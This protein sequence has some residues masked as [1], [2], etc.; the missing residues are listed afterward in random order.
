MGVWFS[1]KTFCKR[2]AIMYD[3]DRQ[4]GKHA[5]EIGLEWLTKHRLP[6]AIYVAWLKRVLARYCLESESDLRSALI[7]EH[8]LEKL[9][10]Q[11]RLWS[12]SFFVY[13]TDAGI[14]RAYNE[15][16]PQSRDVVIEA[17]ERICRHEFELLGADATT[18]GSPLNWHRDPKSGYCWPRL[19]FAELR[20]V[21]SVDNDADVKLPYEFSR[22]Q[23]LPTLGIAY[24]LTRDE[25][26]AE[27]LVAQVSHWLDENPCLMGVNWTCGMD[28]AMRIVNILWGMAFI[29]PQSSV[30]TLAFKQRLLASIWEHGQYLVRHLELS[31][32]EDGTLGNH[33]HYLSNITGLVYLG[34]L[35]PEFKAAERWRQLG[36][37]GLIEEM[38]RQVLNDGADYESSLSYHRLVVELFT[39]SAVLCRLND[40]DLPDTFWDKLEK[41]YTLTLYATR[42]DGRMPQVGD[43]DDGRLHI[44]SGYGQWD[45]MD[46][47][48]LLAIGAVLFERADMK[49]AADGK[50]EEAFWL[51]GQQGVL[52]FDMLA[53]QL[54]LL[55]SRAFPDAGLYVMRS[56]STYLLV[57]CGAVNS[58]VSGNHKHNDLLSFELCVGDVPFIIDPG[59]Y[60]Y[61][62][63][64]EWRNRFRSTAYHNTVVI[65][66]VEQNRFCE[67]Q[68]FR[69][70]PD[71]EVVVHECLLTDEYDRLEV[72]HAG[73]QRLSSPVSHRRAFWFDKRSPAL[74][75]TDVL[76]GD[77]EHQAEWYYH[78]DYG[79]EVSRTDE[80]RFI[81]R[82]GEV[83]LMIQIGA[84]TA[85]AAELLDGWVSRRYGVKLP[86]RILKLCS[87]FSGELRVTFEATGV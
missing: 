82:A 44:L 38:D 1:F 14:W 31:V 57:S 80:A 79:V 50:V 62:G 9:V 68:L 24:G 86:S 47:R 60:I 12:Q 49:A 75:I 11:P 77:G 46:H 51:L 7:Y 35:F 66:A 13:P 16:L 5:I 3:C 26:Y 71:A 54:P 87:T 36:I 41:M 28:V 2:L 42:P 43:A 53:E 59:A 84:E 85:L 17:A 40:V 15:R 29:I 52:V 8:G 56:P 74:Q 39:S 63:A 45:R 10:G 37:S 30:A 19:F 21:T 58:A 27:E 83:E 6:H 65:D 64:P 73:Y 81:A 61:T 70:E 20:P 32:R 18:W 72:E 76:Q 69:M 48:Y 22:L 25:R 23:H 67:D 34:L 4:R 55:A 78:F 33:N